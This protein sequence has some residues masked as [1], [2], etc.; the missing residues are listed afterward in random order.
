MLRVSSFFH[1][2]RVRARS[3]YSWFTPVEADQY[4]AANPAY[5][6]IHN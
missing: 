2:V 4:Q 1:S 6:P 5:K 3:C